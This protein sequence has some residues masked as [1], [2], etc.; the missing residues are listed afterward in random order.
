MRISD[1]SSDV[2]S[3]DLL[4]QTAQAAAKPAKGKAPARKTPFQIVTASFNLSVLLRL[5][6]PKLVCFVATKKQ[7]IRALRQNSSTAT[8]TSDAAA[9]GKRKKTTQPSNAKKS[10]Q[11][12]HVSSVDAEA[13][14]EREFKQD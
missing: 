13:A 14:N 1:W 10:K 6:K 8:S 9:A 7:S 12:R 11:Q 4:R 5:L 3:S 2:C